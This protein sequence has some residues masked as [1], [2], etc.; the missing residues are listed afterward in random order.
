[1]PAPEENVAALLRV[2]PAPQRPPLRDAV[3]DRRRGRR[4]PHAARSRS[5]CGGRPRS[6]T[7]SS[8]PRTPTPSSTSVPRWR[9]GSHRRLRAALAAWRGPAGRVAGE[10]EV[11]NGPFVRGSARGSGGSSGSSLV[12][13]RRLGS[14]RE[15]AAGRRRWREDG[16]GPGQRGPPRQLG[17]GPLRSSSSS[18]SRTGGT[19]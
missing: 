8:A 16:R 18:R 2:P 9:S 6:S 3:R 1:M 7:A 17:Q 15:R 19:S 14:R 5:K 12:A 13:G 4:L 11:R 10:P